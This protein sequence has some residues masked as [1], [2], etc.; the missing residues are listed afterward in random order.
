MSADVNYTL[1]SL[2]EILASHSSVAKDLT[3]LG[4][5]LVSLHVWSHRPIDTASHLG[6]LKPSA[7]TTISQ[8]KHKYITVQHHKI[9]GTS[10]FLEEALMEGKKQPIQQHPLSMPNVNT[11]SCVARN[12]VDRDSPNVLCFS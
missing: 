1:F 10:D 12:T 4:H 7:F 6:R 8:K 5:D 2:H 9:N 11:L 3:P